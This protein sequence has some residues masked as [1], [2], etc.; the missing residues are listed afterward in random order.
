MGIQKGI[1]KLIK[2]NDTDYAIALI[3][4]PGELNEIV[5]DLFSEGFKNEYKNHKVNKDTCI[6]KGYGRLQERNCYALS[7]PN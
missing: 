5:E 4:N 2:E 3:G 6:D 1:A 7:V